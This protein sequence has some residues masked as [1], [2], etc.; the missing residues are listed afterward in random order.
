MLLEQGHSDES[1][2]KYQKECKVKWKE[3]YTTIIM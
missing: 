1:D 2:P 3:L